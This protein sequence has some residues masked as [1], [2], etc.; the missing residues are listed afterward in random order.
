MKT[1]YVYLVV[2]LLLT[3]CLGKPDGVEPV[4]NFEL[5][6]YLGKWYEIARL[7]HSFERGLSQVTANYSLRDDGGVKVLNR[8]YSEERK[9]WKQAEGKAYFVGGDDRGYLKVSFFG[10]FYGS[11]IVF[12]LDKE[13]YQYAFVSG[14]DKTYLWLLARTP[15]VDKALIERF[16]TRARELGFATDKLIFVEH[17]DRPRNSD[18]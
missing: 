6:K 14:P 7:D 13:N 15:E 10:P 18:K 1:R 5:Q 11:Y 16:K 9:E 12:E 17:K 2:F 8:G 4:G 3:G